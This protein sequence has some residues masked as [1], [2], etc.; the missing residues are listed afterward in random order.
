MG[1]RSMK[2]LTSWLELRLR[3]VNEFYFL[4]PD[5]NAY[6]NILDIWIIPD[7]RILKNAKHKCGVP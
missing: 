4:R 6:I 2:E 5:S 1:I 3:E 7:T